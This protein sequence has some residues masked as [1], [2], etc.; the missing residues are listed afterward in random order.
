M[1]S[2]LEFISALSGGNKKAL[3]GEKPVVPLLSEAQKKAIEA[4]KAALPA[5]KEQAADINLFT[6]EQFNRMLE[7]AQPG[8]SALRDRITKS[9]E[10]DWASLPKDVVD[11]FGRVVAEKGIG[12]GTFG[13][14]FNRFDEGRHILKAS[15]ELYRERRDSASRWIAAA[16]SPPIFDFT[17]MFVPTD[18]Q[19]QTEWMR[20]LV[21]AAP[22][23]QDR[24]VVDMQMS[25]LGMIL[26]IYGGGAGYTGQYK[27]NYGGQPQQ[28]SGGGGG[29]SYFYN[30]Q[31]ADYNDAA[32]G[33]SGSGAPAG[34]YGRD[35][36]AANEGM[37]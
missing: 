15:E 32:Y 4:N 20:S 16:K 27:P 36:G 24:G 34:D 23:P 33:P 26:S 18:Q 13:T 3:Y 14:Q 5:L 19:Y 35:F 31:P 22:N 1:A 37:A 2:G 7:L 17:K 10:G 9:Y 6:A 8:Y 30:P 12:R 29:Q 11:Y 28:G 25:T 21:K